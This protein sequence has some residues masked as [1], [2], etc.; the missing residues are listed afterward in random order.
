[1]AGHSHA[2]NVAVRKGKADK[3]KAKI[4]TKIAREITVAVKSGAPDPDANPRLRAA[5]AS[6]RAANMTNDRIKSAIAQ[7]TGAN[8]GDDYEEMRYEGYGVGGIAVIVEALTDNRN[9]TASEVRSAFT[10]HGGNLG[11]TNSVAFS[12]EKVGLIEYPAEKASADAM[13]EAVIDAGADDCESSE[14]IHSIYCKPENLMEVREALSKKFGDADT[15]RFSWKPTNTIAVSGEEAQ[16]LF[17][18]IEALEDFDDVQFVVT[19]AD[20]DQE[21]LNQL[22][23]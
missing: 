11:E 12:F 10:K 5:I 7:G 15:A 8:K 18:M 21:T 4:F 22:A 1:M 14:A 9:R 3:A 23:S 6:A 20:F 17:K 19:N 16:K 2:A 13:L